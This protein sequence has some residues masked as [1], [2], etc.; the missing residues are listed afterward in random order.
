M[1]YSRATWSGVK[2]QRKSIW[3]LSGLRLRGICRTII[4]T[5]LN[6]LRHKR[7]P[8]RGESL[9]LGPTKE[10]TLAGPARPSGSIVTQ[11]FF[12]FPL[13]FTTSKSA[14]KGRESSQSILPVG[15]Y[16]NAGR[17]TFHT[18]PPRPVYCPAEKK[19]KARHEK[20]E[21]RFLACAARHL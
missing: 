17:R 21:K 6:P 16:G 1:K 14:Q 13:F 3:Q 12:L 4:E 10:A 7:R 15:R 9:H 19:H 8:K 20:R 2:D 11:H 18:F 5:F